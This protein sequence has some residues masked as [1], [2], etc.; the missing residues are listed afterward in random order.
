MRILIVE[1]EA[2]IREGISEF[3]QSQ[4]YEVAEAS[5]GM[6]GLEV[7]R[8]FQPDLVILDIMMPRMGGLAMLKE[9]RKTSR[10]PVLVL[11][12]M[13]DEK[14]QVVSFDALADDFISKPFSLL[15]LKKRVEALLRR[16]GK[17]ESVW[18]CGE[19]KVDFDGFQAW[20]QGEEADLKPKEIRLLK[21]LVEHKGQVL[22]RQQMLDQLWDVEEAPFDRVIDVYIKNLR[23]K[24]HLECITTVKGVGYKVQ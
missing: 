17:S 23:K 14:T 11:T 22:S 2:P 7:F 15:I 13:S 8:K 20:Y 3:L 19:A 21:Y 24:L 9:I 6:E 4:D 12:A 16:S 5:D 1:D 18:T 10:L